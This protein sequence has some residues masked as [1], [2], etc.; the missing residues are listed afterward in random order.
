MHLPRQGRG[1][2]SSARLRRGAG[3]GLARPV[4]P[5]STG[6]RCNALTV[7]TADMGFSFG[8]KGERP[9]LAGT[10]VPV[11]VCLADARRLGAGLGGGR[12]MKALCRLARAFALW[13][14]AVKLHVI[15][16]VGRTA[17]RNSRL[18]KRPPWRIPGNSRAGNDC[19]ASEAGLRRSRGCEEGFVDAMSTGSPYSMVCV[20][21]RG[22]RI[23]ACQPKTPFRPDI[24][25]WR[26]DAGSS[27]HQ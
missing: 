20:Q 4:P 7:G 5:N 21:T 12:G 15:G 23:G 17:D 1:R 16:K 19:D 10:G 18:P 8:E 14:A 25:G 2:N 6:T 11:R 3:R 27:S 9:T 24:C 22:R 26:P 13:R